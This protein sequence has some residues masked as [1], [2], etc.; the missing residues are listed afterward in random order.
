L[1]IKAGVSAPAFPLSGKAKIMKATIIRKMLSTLIAASCSCL[2]NTS[3]AADTSTT[4]TN[5]SENRV[6]NVKGEAVTGWNQRMGSAVADL[7]F[8]GRMSLSLNGVCGEKNSTSIDA[9]T[10]LD[11]LLCTHA[12]PFT[13][14]AIFNFEVTASIP[15][16]QNIPLQKFPQIYSSTG[17]DSPLPS[18][19]EAPW[20]Q[21]SNGSLSGGYTVA[22]WL[23]AEGSLKYICG[24]KQNFYE[25]EA[26]HL[27][28]GGLYTLW[29]FYFDQ[30]NAQPPE[31]SGG[32]QPDLAFGG[33]SANVF[34]ADEEGKISGKRIINFCPQTWPKHEQYQP[35]NLHLVLHPEG[36][37]YG[38]VAEQLLKPPHNGGPGIVALP[39]LMFTFPK[40]MY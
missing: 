34:V 15:L 38:T 29:L 32:L 16:H 25:L 8:V 6:A 2:V 13:Y 40:S 36:Q 10:Q 5:Y 17:S 11:A 20:F 12:D 3:I 19:K 30:L 37:V 33:S 1:V 18:V 35:L 24:K 14:K 22:S 28:P 26:R 4:D 21:P 7:P 23:K 27:V 31:G 39:Q 9:S